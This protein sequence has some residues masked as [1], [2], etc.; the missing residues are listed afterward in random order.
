MASWFAAAYGFGIRALLG[1]K[2]ARRVQEFLSQGR[3]FQVEVNFLNLHQTPLYSRK[4]LQV[5]ERLLYRRAY[6]NRNKPARFIAEVNHDPAMNLAGEET[7]II[8]ETRPD[9]LNP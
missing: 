9:C 2:L 4:T 8:Y 1:N 7:T 3:Q 5:T 6:F